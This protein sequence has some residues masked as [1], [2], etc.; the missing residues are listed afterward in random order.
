MALLEESFRKA[1]EADDR[2]PDALLHQPSAVRYGSGDPLGPLIDMPDDGL[3]TARRAAA[4]QSLAWLAG[5]RAESSREMGRLDEALAHADEAVHNAPVISPSHWSARLLSRALIHRHQERRETLARPRGG[6]AYRRVSR[7]AGRRLASLERGPARLAGR[8]ARSRGRAGRL[9]GRTNE[10]TDPALH[11]RSRTGPHGHAARGRGA[12]RNGSGGASRRSDAAPRRCWR[13]A[14]P[15]STRS[16]WATPHRGGRG[17]GLPGVRLS[18][19]QRGCA[20]RC[21]G[22]RRAYRAGLDGRS[23]LRGTLP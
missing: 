12:P 19:F 18:D 23:A 22:P 9:G 13:L 16:R 14:M 15:G 5:N 8:C 1:R 3:R 20:G 2:S 21:R 11:R 7:A 6:G 4:T 10:P 17:C